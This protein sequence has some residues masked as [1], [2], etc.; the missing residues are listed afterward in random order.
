M[1]CMQPPQVALVALERPRRGVEGDA[2]LDPRMG[3]GG[4]IL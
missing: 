1:E 2:T 3:L 4:F